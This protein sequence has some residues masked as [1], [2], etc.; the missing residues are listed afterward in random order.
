MVQADTPTSTMAL[1]APAMK[2]N[3]IHANSTR[4][5]PIANVDAATKTRPQRIAA[6]GRGGITMH[7]SAPAR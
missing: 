7:V 1:A 3:A 5:N 4:V 6:V 2:R